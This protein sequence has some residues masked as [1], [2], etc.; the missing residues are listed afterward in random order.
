MCAVEPTSEAKA[1][2]TGTDAFAIRVPEEA[3]ARH[4]GFRTPAGLWQL[5]L[6]SVNFEVGIAASHRQSRVGKSDAD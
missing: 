5:S 4:A 1:T 3:P 6:R 2:R